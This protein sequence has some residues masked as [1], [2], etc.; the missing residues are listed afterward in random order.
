MNDKE[1]ADIGYQLKLNSNNTDILV[2]DN[3]DKEL[4]TKSDKESQLKANTF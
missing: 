2:D 1:L 4:V 3:S